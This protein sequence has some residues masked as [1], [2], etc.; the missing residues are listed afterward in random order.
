MSPQGDPTQPAWSRPP[1]EEWEIPDDMTLDLPGGDPSRDRLKLRIT[2]LRDSWEIVEFALI[3]Q[4]HYRS[5]WR[6]VSETD[7]VHDTDVHRHQYGRSTM[8]R[9]GKQV[10]LME[11]TCLAD[12]AKGYDLA[13]DDLFQNWQQYRR[14]WQDG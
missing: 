10:Q 3:Q 1:P 4:T 2:N 9:I 6:D 11:L 7:S 14:R 8:Q 13:C 5:K 12:V